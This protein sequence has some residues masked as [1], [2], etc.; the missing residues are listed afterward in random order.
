MLTIKPTAGGTERGLL[1]LRK[2][3]RDKVD[4]WIEAGR[5]PE[6]TDYFDSAD[7]TLG[8]FPIPQKI[9]SPAPKINQLFWPVIGAARYAHGLFLIDGYTL[10][11]LQVDLGSSNKVTLSFYDDP[12]NLSE[13]P[14]TFPMYLLAVR[15]FVQTDPAARP[16]VEPTEDDAWVLVLVD[17]RY[18]WNNAAGTTKA[19]DWLPASWTDLLTTLAA[20]MPGVTSALTI[21]D[22][23]PA[24]YGSPTA[25]WRGGR[26]EGFSLAH[27]LDAAAASCGGRIV[28]TPSTFAFQRPTAA[29]ITTVTGAHTT[30]VAANRHT[31]GGLLVTADLIAGAEGTAVCFFYDGENLS[32]P[33]TARWEIA[34]GG[35]ASGRVTA[36][37]DL[38]AGATAAARQ[39]AAAQWAA[40]WYNWQL[41][42]LD[43]GYTGI[44]DVPASGYVDHVLVYHSDTTAYTKIARPPVGY[45]SLYAEGWECLDIPQY[46]PDDSG[47]GSGG[48][49]PSIP[50][51]NLDTEEIYDIQCIE[52]VQVV[53]RGM[54]AHIQNAGRIRHY[55][56]GL[57]DTIEGCCDCVSGPYSSG[58]SGYITDL[59]TGSGNCTTLTCSQCVLGA[60]LFWKVTL[61]RVGENCEG[62]I[63]TGQ[64]TLSYAP[65][66]TTSCRWIAEAPPRSSFI[67]FFDDEDNK[68]YLFI[69]DT[70]NT[71]VLAVYTT[72]ANIWNCL[73]PNQMTK[74]A[75]MCGL[76]GP[77]TIITIEPDYA[78]CNNAT[79]T[80]SVPCC[81]NAISQNLNLNV[82]T[83][84]DFP[85]TW[86][87]ANNQWETGLITL[88]G[89][90]TV[91]LALSPCGDLDTNNFVLG[92]VLGS[93]ADCEVAFDALTKVVACS[94][95]SYVQDG[96]LSG[97]GCTC[98][99]PFT[100]TIT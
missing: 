24:A 38:P 50:G 65:L 9:E 46:P 17:E 10:N 13:V 28:K 36:W 19:A 83:V 93:G 79:N 68:W 90:G 89:C 32:C 82:S 27:L 66:P 62:I 47:S 69:E 61:T 23:P 60:P 6:L 84:G 41:V 25:R 15:P 18:Y 72:P 1:L 3:D 34:T 98:A 33:N 21:T 75:S 92:T 31:T 20:H 99:G 57:Y 74:I 58:G 77:P 88:T 11:L 52:G 43:A 87:E 70:S 91:S 14:R 39:A 63:P 40:D 35:L 26:I 94:P 48:N 51:D 59:I 86:N 42:P 54:V 96:G 55:W 7:R 64:V 53:T 49:I 30:F 29:H 67:L 45:C 37:L 73:G 80:V 2:T 44:V 22:T 5:V 56:Y 4:S 8:G 78:P 85:M 97:A 16:V 100:F 12:D 71:D 95:F 76:L 81:A